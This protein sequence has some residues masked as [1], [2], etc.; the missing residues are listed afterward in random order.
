MQ[1]YHAWLQDELVVKPGITISAQ[2]TFGNPL[3][4]DRAKINETTLRLTDR[5]VTKS[6]E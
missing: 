5:N 4:R 6:K 3:A 2:H 1:N